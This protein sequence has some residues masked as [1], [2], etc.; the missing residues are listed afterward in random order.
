LGRFVLLVVGAGL[1][2]ATP[3]PAAAHGTEGIFEM[4]SSTVVAPLTAVFRVRLIYANDADPVTSGASVTVSGSG[5]GG[6][7]GPTGLAYTGSN[8]VYEATVT[9]PAGGSWTMTFSSSN[10][11][12]SY[13]HVTSVP[14]PTPSTQPPPPVAPPPP[15]PLPPVQPSI[16]PPPATSTTAATIVAPTE[17]SSTTIEPASS[18]MTTTGKPATTTSIDEASRVE[19][20]DAGDAGY[21]TAAVAVGVGSAIAAVGVSMLFAFR[22]RGGP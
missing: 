21:H 1:T 12:A 22:G 6:S 14:D 9:F 7:V 2:F 20:V 10:P 17:T 5:S 18:S 3:A 11:S 13:V 8:G 19:I 16:A 4:Q 15:T